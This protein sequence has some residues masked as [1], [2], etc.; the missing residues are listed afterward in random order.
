MAVERWGEG[1]QLRGS[2]EVKTLW[3]AA[4]WPEPWAHRLASLFPLLLPRSPLA[5]GLRARPPQRDPRE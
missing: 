5:T 1:L 3:L 2:R 4:P